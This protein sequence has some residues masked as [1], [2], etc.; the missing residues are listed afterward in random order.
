MNYKIF[1]D[2]SNH[3]LTDK[4]DIMVNGAILIDE[5]KVIETNKHIKY[6]RHK[7]NYHNEI[8]W[9]KLINSQKEFYKA[10]IDYFFDSEFMKFKATLVV[11][12]SNQ[13]H[14]QYNRTHDDFYYVVYYY[15][16]RNFLYKD[17]QYKIYLDY[18]DTK[19]SKKSKEL[20]KVLQNSRFTNIN[21][22]IIHS[23]ESNIIQMCDL[24]IGAIG[25]KNRQDLEH[26]SEIK[27][28]II[29]CI[30]ARCGYEIVSTRPWI[31]KFNIF[32][33]SL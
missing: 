18:K 29:G 31:E 20:E 16:L 30:E 6:L 7:Y 25:Y 5:D 12:K 4:S 23:Y 21:F 8:K 28:Y 13:K 27:N 11:N 22:Y 3:L 2:E 26:V 24:F 33:W 14:E 10:L 9:T 32:R 15:T 19:G 17:N 1:C